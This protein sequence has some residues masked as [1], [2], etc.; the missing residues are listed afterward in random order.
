MCASCQRIHC[1]ASRSRLGA[2]VLYDPALYDAGCATASESRRSSAFPYP[3][4]ACEQAV[5]QYTRDSEV[6]YALQDID[7]RVASGVY[8][9][10][11]VERIPAREV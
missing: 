6:G 11:E 7:W 8:S 10:Q 1:A 5:G 9:R 2:P 3:F 4:T